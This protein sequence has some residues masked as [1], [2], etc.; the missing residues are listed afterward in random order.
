MD[1]NNTE[2]IE[3]QESASEVDPWEAAFAALEPK[4]EESS[5]A[6]S[7]DTGD[8]GNSSSDSKESDGQEVSNPDENGN[9]DSNEND[10]GGLD[11]DA[12]DDREE[13][14]NAFADRKGITEEQIRQYKTESSE[15]IRNQAI[16]EIAKEFMKRDEVRKHNGTL[17][18]T[19]NDPDIC[20]R[21]EDGVPRFY[22]PDTGREFTGDN[23]RRQAQ[24]WVDDYNAELARVFNDACGK[25]E[26]YLTDQNAPRLAVLE[27]AP[28]YEALDPIR[29]GMLDN[30]LEDYEL[31]DGSGK[32]FG[33]SCDLDK[34]LALVERQVEMIR[35]YAKQRK[36]ESK[37][38]DDKP[39]GPALD[40]KTSSGAVP[41]GGGAA[42]KS[43]AE[44]MERL[45]DEQL[46]KLK[47]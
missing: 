20:K 6:D 25:Y 27:F 43:L 21:D 39:K 38:I 33:Y 22:N 7:S 8:T 45:Q 40:M 15:R 35:S 18:A 1:P 30:V 34:A 41:S 31:K 26:R 46:S 10:A 5:E 4:S 37:T 47:K 17:G 44:A 42:P 3:N 14:G 11:L 24:E 13:G 32:V 28:K 9:S 2:Q 16:D 19:I 36:T 23:P 29:K 12:G